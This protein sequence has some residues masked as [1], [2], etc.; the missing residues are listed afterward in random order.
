M[1][2]GGVPCILLLMGLALS[3]LFFYRAPLFL[4]ATCT[5]FFLL[6]PPHHF[7][8]QNFRAVTLAPPRHL[9]F[10]QSVPLA[11]GYLVSGFRRSR[12][13]SKINVLCIPPFVVLVMYLINIF[14]FKFKMSFLFFCRISQTKLRHVQ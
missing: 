12:M 9:N 6:G 13:S 5:T 3:F 7:F 2:Y 1:V 10:G 11:C 8:I 4:F 14:R